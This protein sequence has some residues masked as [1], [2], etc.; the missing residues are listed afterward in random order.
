[1]SHYRIYLMRGGHIKV[2]YDFECETDACALAEAESM[3]G[4][5]AR[6]SVWTGTRQVGFVGVDMAVV[7]APRWKDLDSSLAC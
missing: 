7:K 4:E 1:M 5:Y 3:L 6:A 2:G